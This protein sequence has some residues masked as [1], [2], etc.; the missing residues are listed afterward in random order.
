MVKKTVIDKK[1]KKKT[2]DADIRVEDNRVIIDYSADTDMRPFALLVMEGGDT[3]VW[4]RSL[5]ESEIA[6]RMISEEFRD[7][8]CSRW[9]RLDYSFRIALKCESAE[10]GDSNVAIVT[11]SRKRSKKAY[12]EPISL[13]NITMENGISFQNIVVMPYHME[14]NGQFAIRLSEPE[15]MMVKFLRC[16]VQT[17][18]YEGSRFVITA[19]MP[20]PEK[21]VRKVLL[22]SRRGDARHPME[23]NVAE[24]GGKLEVTAAIDLKQIELVDPFWSI[25]IETEMFGCPIWIQPSIPNK[26]EQHMKRSA[27]HGYLNDDMIFY[28][29]PLKTGLC[30]LVIRKRE[31]FDSR[32]VRLKELLAV[33]VFRVFGSFYKGKGYWLIFEKFCSAAQ[34]NGY[35]FFR[36]CMENLSEKEKKH[37]YYVIDRNSSAYEE[38]K[39]YGRNIVAFMSL[40]HMLYCLAADM[41]VASESKSHLYAWRG[42]P[43]LI[44]SKIR[45]KPIFFLQHGVTALKRVDNIFGKSGTDPMTYFVA[46]SKKEQDIIVDNFGYPRENVPILGFT[47]WDKLEDTSTEDNRTILVMPTWRKWIQDSGVNAFADSDY[48]RNYSGLLQNE[49]LISA[50]QN[51]NIRLLFY[52]HPKFKEYMGEL[53]GSMQAESDCCEVIAFG[54]K[55]LNELIQSSKMVITDYSSVCWDFYYL[56]KPVVFYQFD[57]DLYMKNH[58]SYIDMTRELCGDRYLN[59]GKLVEGILN[60]I[61][62]GFQEKKQFADMRQDLFEFVD[63]NNCRRTYDYLR[64]IH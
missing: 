29:G 25:C 24:K 57:Y 9:A 5:E 52:M 58:G 17:V 50:L 38:V 47:R 20:K 64:I 33:L 35:A 45:N 41:Y 34:D 62:N 32:S 23:C 4:E 42:K 60:Y 59:E 48:F 18:K 28:A 21:P 27:T 12:Y 54:E 30:Q 43:S 40:R 26:L 19:V 31:F 56:G 7:F 2:I 36:F 3:I 14:K 37:I 55:P 46:T 13:H 16:D 15:R 53:S 6:D 1:I 49:K 11:N 22:V 63:H 51:N 39:K 8:V 10:Q 61:Y 44:S